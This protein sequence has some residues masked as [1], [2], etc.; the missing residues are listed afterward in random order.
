MPSMK[1]GNHRF[2][3]HVSEIDKKSSHRD[4][5]K[6][7][8]DAV[9]RAK[10]QLPLFHIYWKCHYLGTQMGFRLVRV[11]ALRRESWQK[12]GLENITKKRHEKTFRFVQQWSKKRVSKK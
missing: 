8:F 7:D 11:D 5:E 9:S 3:Q 10:T 4:L 2:R 6:L 12:W 1:G